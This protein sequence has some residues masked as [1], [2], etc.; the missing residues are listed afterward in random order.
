M[1]LSPPV[2]FSQQLHPVHHPKEYTVLALCAG[3]PFKPSMSHLKLIKSSRWQ[4]MFSAFGCSSQG[5]PE[6]STNM[7]CPSLILVHGLDGDPVKSWQ[8]G[9]SGVVWPRDL[10]PQVLPQARVLSFAYNADAYNNKSTSSTRVLAWHLLS[11]LRLA[12]QDADPDRAIVFIAHNIGGLVV[13]HV[14]PVSMYAGGG[15]TRPC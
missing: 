8:H 7:P 12:R 5:S 14:S 3:Y 2:L 10:L 4:S 13:K 15:R 11:L 9:D 6:H 1:Q